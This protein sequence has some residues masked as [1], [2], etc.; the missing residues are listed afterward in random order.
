MK[1]SLISILSI[2]IVLMAWQATA[3]AENLSDSAKIF[4]VQCAGCHPNGGNIIRRGKSLQKKAL[5]KN[6]ME[7][8]EAIAEIVTYGKNN[9]SAF[10]DRL[11]KQEIEAVS[12]YVLERAENNW[13]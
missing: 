9:M 2:L 8:L 5:Q 1:R 13:K 6:Q 11:S 12:A 3:L 10:Q 7:S 4:N